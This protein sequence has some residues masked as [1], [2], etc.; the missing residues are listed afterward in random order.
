MQTAKY[1]QFKFLECVGLS[2]THPTKPAFKMRVAPTYVYCF[3]H[4]TSRCAISNTSEL[5]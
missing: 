3:G 4:I 1:V 5:I 2:L